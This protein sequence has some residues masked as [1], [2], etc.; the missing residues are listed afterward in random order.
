MLLPNKNYYLTKMRRDFSK[1]EMDEDLYLIEG[2]I[3]D[4]EK[5]KYQM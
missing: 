1:T 4:N 2:K 3:G 5:I